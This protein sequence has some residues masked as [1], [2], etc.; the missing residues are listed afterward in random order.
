MLV[1][2]ILMM[3]QT[4]K[5]QYLNIS[6]AA[7]LV[8]IILSNWALA[9]IFYIHPDPQGAIAIF[10]LPP[11]QVVLYEIVYVIGRGLNKKSEVSAV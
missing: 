2:C 6:L 3:V 7:V 1:P 8:T 10:M 9:D 11:I 4:V 5:S